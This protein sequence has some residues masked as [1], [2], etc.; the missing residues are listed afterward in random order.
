MTIPKAEPWRMCIAAVEGWGKTTVGANAPSPAFLMARGETGYTT[1][2]ARGLAPAVPSVE[3]CEWQHT[4]DTISDLAVNANGIKTVVLDAGS[5]F[6][7]QCV[8]HVC[9]RDF[10]GD[11]G[12]KGFS[13]FG[14][15]YEVA[16]VEWLKLLSALD[17]LRLKQGVNILIL[18][19]IQV[20]Q[21]KNPL[22]ADYDR[23]VSDMHHKIWSPTF[24]WVDVSL[25]GQY[26]TVIDR[27]QKGKGKAIGGTERVCYTSRRD[28][29]DAKNRH[30][31][32]EAI[33]IPSDPALTYATI[34]PYINP[35]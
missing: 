23:Y 26:I 31:M 16:A 1:L 33:D 22:G 15:G 3:L 2:L 12:E 10:A 25:F 19:H 34:A 14:K 24:K 6:E 32:P 29:W 27:E 13:S 9:D 17:T 4:L 8:S 21:F 28:A 7:R 5:G 35:L 18:S 20:K 11:M 30:A